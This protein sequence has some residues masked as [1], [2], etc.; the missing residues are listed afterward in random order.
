MP[1]NITQWKLVALFDMTLKCYV[2]R[3]IFFVYQLQ[4]YY[5]QTGYIC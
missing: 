5:L 1:S 3:H 2:G 4:V